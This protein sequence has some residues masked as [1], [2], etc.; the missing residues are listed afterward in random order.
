MSPSTAT[1]ESDVKKASCYLAI[2]G[3][4]AIFAAPAFGQAPSAAKPQTQAAAP[5]AAAPASAPATVSR[6]TKAVNY[7]RAGGSTKIDF[8]GTELMQGASGEAKVDSKSTHMEI[9][10]KFTGLDDATKFGLEYLTYVLWA[11]S[12][13]GRAVNL[14]EV[15][16]KNGA[17]QVKA[18]S[19]MQTF[20]MIVT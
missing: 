11:V 20:G 13:Q 6:T 8:S 19:D 16:L 15:A 5:Q 7:R 1:E 4:L 9:E 18:I 14:G 12:P 17:G 10:A 2:A 3:T